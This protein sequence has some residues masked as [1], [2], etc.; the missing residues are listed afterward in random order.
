MWRTP[1]ATASVQLSELVCDLPQ[2]RWS[3]R[4][5]LDPL[6][7]EQPHRARG[8]LETGT[9]VISPRRLA[10]SGTTSAISMPVRAT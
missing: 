6:R 3:S 2:T 8:K 4:P 5:K 7:S 1:W 10:S 9:S